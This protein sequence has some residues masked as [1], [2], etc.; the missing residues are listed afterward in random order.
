M[1]IEQ[2]K[3]KLER[4]IERGAKYQVDFDDTTSPEKLGMINVKQ[5]KIGFDMSDF[6][7]NDTG[8][9]FLD[10][11][12]MRMDD[13]MGQFYSPQLYNTPGPARSRAGNVAYPNPQDR[14]VRSSSSRI[15]TNESHRSQAA[16]RDGLYHQYPSN[17]LDPNILL[18][19]HQY[20]PHSP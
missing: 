4:D 9:T 15:H 11:S 3:R 2:M 6:K 19:P 12:K 5:H 14:S 10:P 8:S 7:M 13:I 20:P 16:T 18:V 1:T 17:S